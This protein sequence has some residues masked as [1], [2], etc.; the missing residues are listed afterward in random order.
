MGASCCH[1]LSSIVEPKFVFEQKCSLNISLDQPTQFSRRKLFQ[2]LAKK[3]VYQRFIH[4]SMVKSSGVVFA[5]MR[6][7][8][9]P[10]E[11]EGSFGGS[12][13]HLKRPDATRA[14]EIIRGRPAKFSSFSSHLR[15]NHRKSRLTRGTFYGL[16]LILARLMR[17][18]CILHPLSVRYCL[19]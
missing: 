11:L 13:N 6:K 14:I 19:R 12:Q 15:G 2:K 4:H 8:Q 3:L 10:V 16:H 17:Q 18:K 9:I 7:V 5:W 1:D